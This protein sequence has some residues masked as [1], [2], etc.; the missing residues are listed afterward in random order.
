[1]AWNF[2]RRI[3]ILP[4]VHLNFSKSGIT[5]SIGTGH[6]SVTF[7]K[8]GTYVNTSIP[9]LGLYNRQKVSSGQSDPVPSTAQNQ[10]SSIVSDTVSQDS[11]EVT[12]Q[13]MQGVKNAILA[14]IRQRK[15][16]CRDVTET[17]SALS[18]S[19]FK[20]VAS[21][22]LLYGL[23]IRSISRG[24]KDDINAQKL[25]LLQ[26]QEHIDHCHI[27][28][29]VDFDEPIRDAY[30]RVE[31]SF[32]KV[33]AAQTIWDV[34]D[35]QSVDSVATRSFASTA[36][37]RKEV[38]FGIGPIPDIKWVLDPMRLR[39]ANG[40]DI[41]I[42]PNFFVVYSSVQQFAVV[43][44]DE[45]KVAFRAIQYQELS[46]IP[47]DT[48]VVQQT[49]FK[50]N[51][52]GTPDKR[53]KGN[54]QIPVV[55]YGEISFNTGTGL[56]EKYHVSNYEAV[57]DFANALR[58]YQEMINSL[59][60]IPVGARKN[61]SV[62]QHGGTQPGESSHPTDPPLFGKKVVIEP[63]PQTRVT[64]Q[65]VAEAQRA[66]KELENSIHDPLRKELK[67]IG[68]VSLAKD[69]LRLDIGDLMSRVAGCQGDISRAEGQFY[70]DIQSSMRPRM[71][72]QWTVEAAMEMMHSTLKTSS[73][74]FVKP[75]TLRLMEDHDLANGTKYAALVR[76]LFCQIASL[77]AGADGV[78]TAEE[79]A[80]LKVMMAVMRTERSVL[81]GSSLE[82]SIPSEWLSRLYAVR[83]ELRALVQKASSDVMQ[84]L[85]QATIVGPGGTPQK[86]DS[87]EAQL[88]IDVT[89][90]VSTLAKR[91]GHGTNRDI[92]VICAFRPG[93]SS[94][95]EI[96]RS[97]FTEEMRGRVMSMDFSGQ[98]LCK[99]PIVTL[100]EKCDEI[101]GTA[102]APGFGAAYARLLLVIGDHDPSS[103]VHEVVEEL[104]RLMGT[105]PQ[106]DVVARKVPSKPDV[107]QSSDELLKDIFD[108]LHSL[109][110]LPTVKQDVIDLANGIK[111]DQIRKSQ[112]LKCV[113]RSLH[114]VFCG[115]PGTG[116]TTVARILARIYKALGVV[117]KGQLIETD[118]SGMVAGYVGQT[119]LKTKKLLEQ[120][121]GG[122]LFIDE[123][124]SLAKGADSDDFGREAVETL[125]KFMEDH[126][127]DLIVI[128][129]GYPNEMRDFLE[130][131]PGVQSRFTKSIQFEDYVPAELL[132]IFNVLCKESDYRLSEDAAASLATIL[133]S[134]YD[135]RTRNFG[136]ARFVRN[137][138]ESA[139]ARLANRVAISGKTDT[140]SLVTITKED[141]QS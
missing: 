108:E 16:L 37:Q 120:A 136:N 84:F 44:M 76:D 83:D 116:K 131:N 27:E 8:N 59:A 137:M 124:Y 90:L 67:K 102:Y 123:A 50:V 48:K 47:S 20:L 138:F 49:W 34:V 14:A 133:Q 100:A 7:G 128:V 55:R 98:T 19:K 56:N 71:F 135:A 74:P 114:L 30:T 29:E 140:D 80:L 96:P 113:D 130:S 68:E 28:L 21:Y 66:A 118:R 58:A 1:M 23:I 75:S 53:F 13:N 77:T 134:A 40:G 111:V 24:I 65:Q 91:R 18:S 87:L 5:T 109:I 3:K 26:L 88:P 31:E 52:N 51:K 95:D 125:L 39:S 42:F 12:S 45:V 141:I 82:N 46:T 94:S 119:A 61:D 69:L 104:S 10:P 38:T 107:K 41:F 127:D 105:L 15:E 22:V 9:G 112:G 32:K 126:R 99:P 64:E 78:I 60:E 72:A 63:T 4:G 2:R 86:I 122:I 132:E 73:N 17:E 25:A 139:I 6:A 121:L 54:Y 11:Y 103:E 101:N 93:Q 117:S 129:A 79:A 85:N 43:G 115:N 36:V 92:A 89:Y 106:D 70:L 97:V 110:G 81:E 62:L 57:E 33:C 35:E